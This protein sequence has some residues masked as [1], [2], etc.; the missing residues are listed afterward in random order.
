MILKY[1]Q[2]HILKIH[3]FIEFGGFFINCIFLYI[4]S[5]H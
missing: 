4:K 1:H 2:K 5:H 3:N